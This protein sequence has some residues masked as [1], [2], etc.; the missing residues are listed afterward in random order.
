MFFIVFQKF[1]IILR[2]KLGITLTRTKPLGHRTGIQEELVP[3]KAR[4]KRRQGI[5]GA[6]NLGLH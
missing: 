6:D 1:S 4:T 2:R 5:R 3:E